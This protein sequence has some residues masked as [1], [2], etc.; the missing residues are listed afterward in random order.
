MPRAKIPNIDHAELLRRLA[1]DPLTGVFTLLKHTDPRRIDTAT[2]ATDPRGYV[3]IYNKVDG[4]KC[5]QL[6]HRLAWFYVHGV[7]PKFGIDHKD[8]DRGN[9]ALENLREATNGQNQANTRIYKNNKSGHKGVFKVKESGHWMVTIGYDNKVH[10]VKAFVD[11]T[12][13]VAF[14]RALAERHHGEYARY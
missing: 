9:N 7:W 11:L 3:H 6:A 13:A 1:Y 14:R 8:G 10:N 4:K 5:D 12:E 2:G